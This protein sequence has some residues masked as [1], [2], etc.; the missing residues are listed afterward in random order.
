MIVVP[1]AYKFE[2]WGYKENV[3][4]SQKSADIALLFSVVPKIKG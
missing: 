4:K 1:I 3:K 2:V